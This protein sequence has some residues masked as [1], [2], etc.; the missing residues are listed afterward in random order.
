MLIAPVINSLRKKLDL[1]KTCAG[2]SLAGVS[3]AKS[4]P[5][6]VFY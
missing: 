3:G 4:E 1:K 6:K 2:Q 5:T